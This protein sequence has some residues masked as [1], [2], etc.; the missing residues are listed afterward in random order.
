MWTGTTDIGGPELQVSVPTGAAN[1]RSSCW[2]CVTTV[3][4]EAYAVPTGATLLLGVT[5]THRV[6]IPTAGCPLLKDLYSYV[7]TSDSGIL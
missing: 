5:T 7:A 3:P 4:E 2:C 6:P 1:A